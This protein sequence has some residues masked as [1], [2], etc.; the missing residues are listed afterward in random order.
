M[1]IPDWAQMLITIILTLCL[2]VVLV[3]FGYQ[4][5]KK[6][7]TK[8]KCSFTSLQS[9]DSGTAGSYVQ[10]GYISCEGGG[11]LWVPGGINILNEGPGTFYIGPLPSQASPSKIDA[12]DSINID[13]SLQGSTPPNVFYQSGS[14]YT[15]P[16]FAITIK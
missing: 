13:M 16:S 7:N 4:K 5:Y 14:T 10:T 9:V 1:E 12:L 11:S 15:T 3:Y 2:I 6:L 8:G